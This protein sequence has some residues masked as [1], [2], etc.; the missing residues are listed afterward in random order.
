MH[1]QSCTAWRCGRCG[2]KFPRGERDKHFQAC[3][4]WSCWSCG[5]SAEDLGPGGRLEHI[6]NCSKEFRRCSQCHKA[7]PL[8]DFD[9]HRANCRICP[10]REAT[11]ARGDEK[12]RPI[13]CAAP[14]AP[15]AIQHTSRVLAPTTRYPTPPSPQAAKR[16]WTQNPRRS[17]FLDFEYFTMDLHPLGLAVVNGLGEWII[18]V[19]I[20]KL[21]TST[22][23]FLERMAH[24]GAFSLG[25]ARGTG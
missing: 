22:K 14:L 13:K 17:I 7:I 21:G 9:R 1:I 5:M 6:A 8:P 12:S 10:I 20:I 3:S 11:L 15:E 25:N 2:I 16:D 19:T 24:A 23:A 4:Y 18:P